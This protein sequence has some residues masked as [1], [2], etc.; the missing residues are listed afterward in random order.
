[1]C[2][3]YDVQPQ[4]FDVF[5]IHPVLKGISVLLDEPGVHSTDIALLFA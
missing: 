1:M 2:N 5:E 4:L 3:W